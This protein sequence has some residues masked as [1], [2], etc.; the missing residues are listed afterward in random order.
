MA[1]IQLDLLELLGIQRPAAAP[2]VP[3][4]VSERAKAEVEN[5]LRKEGWE[6]EA[7]RISVAP[8]GG[9]SWGKDAIYKQWGPARFAEAVNRFAPG[10]PLRVILL[11]ERKEEPLLRETAARLRRPALVFAGE[12]IEKV[13]AL[14]LRSRFLLSNDGGL[15]HL[16]NALGTRTVS[17]F[18]PV[19]ENVYGPY[20]REVPNRLVTQSVPCRP[21]YR[22]FYFPPCPFS[23]RCLTELG[24]EKVVAAMK[25]VA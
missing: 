23:G 10:G 20:R 11:G 2:K 12:P 17:I 25:D 4:S 16:A 19:D 7:L 8:G 15:V 14:L 13:S 1:D 22:N 21:C 18:G 9:R 3:L 24:V 6:T 5:F